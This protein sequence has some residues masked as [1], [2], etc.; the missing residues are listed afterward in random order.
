MILIEILKKNLIFSFSKKIPF[1]KRI[2]KDIRIIK[3]DILR[4]FKNIPKLQLYDE[5]KTISPTMIG[6]L[7]AEVFLDIMTQVL[8]VEIIAR[9]S[10]MHTIIAPAGAENYI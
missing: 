5:R 9:C 2:Y 6:L 10:L 7:S 1:L 3:A 4:V 8:L